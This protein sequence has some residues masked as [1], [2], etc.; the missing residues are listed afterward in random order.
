MATSFPPPESYPAGRPDPPKKK[1]SPLVWILV[2]LLGLFVVVALAAVAG[3]LFLAKKV[4]DVASNPAEAA[5]LLVAANPDVEVVS[6]DD[7]GRITVRDKRTGKTVSMNFTDLKNGKLSFE[8]EGKKFSMQANETGVHVK[9]EDGQTVDI[10][11]GVAKLPDWI[12]SYPGGTSAKGAFAMQGGEGQA[13]TLSFSTKD[14]PARVVEFYDS[15][16]RKA[17]MTTQQMLASDGGKTSGG[18]V[19]AESADKKQT[20]M[21][22]VSNSDGET[23][24]AITFSAK[25]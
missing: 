15:A 2:G 5:R 8:D 4:H 9:G 3:G 20:A 14:A 1:I 24:V 18:T 6:T 17:G 22:N 11:T 23:A 25:K 16:L 10:G 12:P 21:V 13:A 7:S 19:T